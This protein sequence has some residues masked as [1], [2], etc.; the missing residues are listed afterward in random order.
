MSEQH[1]TQTVRPGP[2]S[3]KH[4][5]LLELCLREAALAGKPMMERLV[6]SAQQVATQ[7]SVDAA[8][9]DRLNHSMG[10]LRSLAVGLGERFPAHLN[11]AFSAKPVA[12]TAPSLSQLRYDELELMDETQVEEKMEIARALGVINSEVDAKLKALNSLMSTIQGYKAV[13]PERNPLRPESYLDALIQLFKQSEV[14]SDVCV[15]WLQCMTPELSRALQDEYSRWGVALK[16]GGVSA[17]DYTVLMTAGGSSAGGAIQSTGDERIDNRLGQSRYSAALEP[18]PLADARLTVKQLRRLVMGEFDMRR[19]GDEGDPRMVPAS[20]DRR[21]RGQAFENTIPAALQALEEMHRVDDAMQR[22]AQREGTGLTPAAQ[23]ARGAAPEPIE[24]SDPMELAQLET[25]ELYA[26]LRQ[27]SRSVGDVLSLEVV[28]LM[29]ENIVSDTRLLQ[30]VRD[31]VA[32]LESPLLRLVMFDQRFFSEKDHPARRLLQTIAERSAGYESADNPAFVA[33]LQPL[34]Q[35]VQELVRVP[36]ESAEPFELTLDLLVPI[37]NDLQQRERDQH[38]QAVK[39]LMHAEQRNI[40]AGSIGK[41]LRSRPDSGDVPESVLAFAGG[42]W[43]QV[44]AQ[45]RVLA[46]VAED[47]APAAASRLKKQANDYAALVG[48]LYWSVC[49]EKVGKDTD[50]LLRLIPGLLNNLRAGLKTIEYPAKEASAFFDKLMTLH[51]RSLQKNAQVAQRSGWGELAEV[52]SAR[53]K[54][55]ENHDAGKPGAVDTANVWLAPNEAHSSGYLED[56][57]ID[58]TSVEEPETQVM[59]YDESVHASSQFVSMDEVQDITAAETASTAKSSGGM[60]AMAMDASMDASVLRQGEWVNMLRGGSATRAQL[61][62]VSPEQTMYMFT[63]STG[64]NQSMSRGTL[65]RLIKQG[66]VQLL[67]PANVMDNALNAVTQTAMRNSMD[68][69]GSPQR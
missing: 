54:H 22:L 62:W 47:D 25:P 26:R 63:T 36:I 52:S 23:L 50:R 40:E 51:Q 38:A 13:L 27:E 7:P 53:E 56:V 60:V 16:T 20:G 35:A 17:A 33:F 61:I 18:S 34:R 29:V 41:D 8:R 19:H 66:H 55:A 12:A 37:W 11:R 42:P 24:G 32:L 3:A 48:D 65:D 1:V 6:K 4:A 49:P 64:R 21:K 31:I 14:G 39:T 5:A 43:A 69:G 68:S 28:A 58:F 46:K 67:V 2:V 45:V 57:G 30:P 9:R 59:A 44:V 15:D 10:L